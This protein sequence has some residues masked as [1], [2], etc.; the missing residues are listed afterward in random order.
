[1]ISSLNSFRTHAKDGVSLYRS[2]ALPAT[3]SG[4]LAAAIQPT[5]SIA[6][7]TVP[8]SYFPGV[9]QYSN[10]LSYSGAVGCTTV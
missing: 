6:I 7:P 5:G 2:Y 9:S 3:L 8:T 4:D 10:L 1:M